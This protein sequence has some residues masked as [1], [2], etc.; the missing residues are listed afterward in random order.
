[1]AFIIR[2]SSFVILSPMFDWLRAHEVLLGWLSAVSVL[3]FVGSLIAIPYLAT[4]IPTDYFIRQRHY[5]DRWQPRHPLVRLALLA[6]KNLCGVVFVLAGVAMLVLPGQGILTILIG[7]MC[8]DFPG[9]FA[10][11][12]RFVRQPPV[13]G[14]INWMRAKTGHPPLQLPV[15]QA[16]DDA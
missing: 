14:A 3:M 9:K 1:M 6:A 7:L 8:L 4:R 11:E 16:T 15:E 10:L 2:H 5:V 12:R 13:I